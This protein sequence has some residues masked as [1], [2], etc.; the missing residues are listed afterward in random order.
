MR[1]V[2]FKTAFLLLMYLSVSVFL[3]TDI[4][5]MPETKTGDHLL[6]LHLQGV[7]SAKVSL[8]PFIGLKATTPIAEVADLKDGGTA[9]LKIPAQYLPG[10]FVLRLDYRAKEGDSPYPSEKGLFINNQ[11]IELFIDPLH[12]H[13]ADYTKFSDGETENTAY[14]KFMEENNEKRMPI[15]FIKQFLLSYDRPKSKLYL[16][17]VKE[18]NQRRKEYN[19]WLKKQAKINNKLYVSK[20]FQFQH[21][22]AIEWGGDLEERPSQ[23]LKNYFDGIDFSDPIILRSREISML[24]DGYMRLY[25]M[26]ATTEEL[27]DTLFTEAGR[28]ACEEASKGHPEVYGWMVDY[29]YKGYETYGIED[30]MAILKKHVDNPNCLTTKREQITKRLDGIS[31]LVAGAAAPN[32]TATDSTGSN[33]ELYKWKNDSAHKLI[34][35][36][37]PGCSSCKKLKEDLAKWYIEPNNKDK[38]DVLIVDLDKPGSQGAKITKTLP[39]GWKYIHTK[40]GIES[41]IAKDYAILSAP[42]MFLLDNK[43]NAIVSTPFDLDQLIKDLK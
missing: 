8:I 32:F 26:Q 14:A 1:R 15:E 39:A 29:F 38:L 27:R 12:V 21:M 40:G 9:T 42:A 30:G 18:F 2:I 33:F 5:A 17:A 43:D 6:I 7:Y 23:L 13:D 20:L 22:P 16:E 34:L 24:M 25:G 41:S 37:L 28:V 35:F 36:S 19:A 31:R 10:E 11:D 3:N 4:S